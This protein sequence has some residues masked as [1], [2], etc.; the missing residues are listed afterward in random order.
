MPSAPNSITR[1]LMSSWVN[2]T[3]S[4]LNER[5]TSVL[6]VITVSCVAPNRI[7][8]TTSTWLSVCP[9][10]H[11]EISFTELFILL[12]LPT[13]SFSTCQLDLS[14][15]LDTREELQDQFLTCIRYDHND[16]TDVRNSIASIPLSA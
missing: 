6:S 5:F 4:Y 13:D 10:S 15:H 3:G 12:L 9:H 14:V 16:Y 11:K 2:V 8:Q 1:N 7:R